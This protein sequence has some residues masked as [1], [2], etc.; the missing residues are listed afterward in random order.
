MTTFPPGSAIMNI[1]Q[2]IEEAIPL[3]AEDLRDA[4]AHLGLTLAGAAERAGTSAN[5]YRM[6]E[7]GLLRRT[8]E[9]FAAMISLAG[10]LGLE[11]VRVSYVDEDD[12]YMRVGT[13]GN[14]PLFTFFV[15]TL[16][17]NVAQLKEQGLF[18]S[19][20]RVLDLVDH[21]GVGPI[22]DS[23]ERVDKMMVELWVT[24]I[25]AYALCLDGDRD[26]YV[27]AAR[28][29]PPDTEVLVVDKKTG[30][31]KASRVEITQYGKYSTSVTEVIGKKLRKRYQDH[32]ILLVLVERSERLSIVDLDELIQKNNPHG[33]KIC[34]IV[35]AGEA[36]RFKVLPWDEVTAAPTPGLMTWKEIIVDTKDRSKGRCEY[37]GVVYDPPPTSKF[38]RRAFPV[39]I[40]EIELHR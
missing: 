34:I 6:I 40:R 3:I 15:D 14:A 5:W 23:R 8:K 9:G 13:A 26:Y 31:L 32:T 33:Q 10:H 30:C 35:G 12:Q 27:R 21:E 37:D 29:D 4:R 17:S 2:L 36:G 16:D 38:S 24:A 25:Y 11:S 28:D 19:P 39:F 1:D 18:V 20:H 7:S 22:L